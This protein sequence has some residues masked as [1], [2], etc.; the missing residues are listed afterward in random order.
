VT[1]VIILKVVVLR[2]G[3]PQIIHRN[4]ISVGDIVKVQN[5]MNL[6]V[7]GIVIEGTG[8]MCDESAMT[9]ESDH[10]PKESVDKCQVKMKECD[11]DGEYEKGPHDVPSPVLLSGTQI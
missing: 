10:L 6:P 4:Y 3:K 1:D 8:I 9:G 7:D 11:A 5:G 2:D